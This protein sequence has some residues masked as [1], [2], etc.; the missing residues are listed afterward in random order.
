MIPSKVFA[1]ILYNSLLDRNSV[2]VL[3]D[4]LI[5]FRGEHIP[6]SIALFA[7]L[8]LTHNMSVMKYGAK[9]V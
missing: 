1:S 5:L 3:C 4:Q 2:N 7:N 9:L 8:E 6:L